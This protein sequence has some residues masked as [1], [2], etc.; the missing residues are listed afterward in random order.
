[1]VACPIMPVPSR[2]LSEEHLAEVFKTV[3]EIEEDV[4]RHECVSSSVPPPHF[5]WASAGWFHFG[6]GV[7]L[8]IGTHVCARPVRGLP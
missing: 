5:L 4:A 7:S 1:M 2:Q 3:A 6:L 8:F